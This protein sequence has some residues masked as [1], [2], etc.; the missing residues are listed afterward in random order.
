MT[1]ERSLHRIMPVSPRPG[2]WPVGLEFE[3]K[4]HQT[5]PEQATAWFHSWS[6]ICLVASDTHIRAVAVVQ[7]VIPNPAEQASHPNKKA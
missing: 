6:S 2:F 3:S 7:A 5:Q 4:S 1:K